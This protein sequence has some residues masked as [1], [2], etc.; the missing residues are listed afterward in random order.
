[1]DSCP[2][3]TDAI[4][5]SPATATLLVDVR[6]P[7]S[8]KLLEILESYRTPEKVHCGL[9]GC[10]TSHNKGFL[11][12]FAES[13]GVASKV[14]MVGHICGRN[15]FNA[16]WVTVQQAYDVRIRTAEVKAAEERFRI[17]AGRIIP[18][19]QAATPQLKTL[20]AARGVLTKYASDIMRVC[21][22]AAKSRG[23]RIETYFGHEVHRLAGVEF[24]RDG[25]TA[26]LSVLRLQHEVDQFLGYISSSEATKKEVGRRLGGFVDIENQ[27]RLAS[28]TLEA[29]AAALRPEH[30]RQVFGAACQVLQYSSVPG[31]QNDI[32]RF[33]PHVRIR[34]SMLEYR[35]WDKH[36]SSF[37]VQAR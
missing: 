1:M 25:G 14:G 23:G 29:A 10:R 11:V 20:I 27:W 19:L 2:V 6:I 7:R 35:D 37:W 9:E 4:P 24:W 15:N 21:A 22:D 12:L 28:K 17:R 31:H 16:V 34:G 36:G 18:E 5:A 26:L 8:A 3:D 33:D 30:L 13:E 32:L